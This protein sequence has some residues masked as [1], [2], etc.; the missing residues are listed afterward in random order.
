MAVVGRRFFY[1]ATEARHS[2]KSLLPTTATM[3]KV[4][5]GLLYLGD[6][7]MTIHG[8][9][10]ELNPN[11]WQATQF[12][13]YAKIRDFVFNMGLR[14]WQRQ[15]KQ[16]MKPSAW[17][18]RKQ[19]NGVKREYFPEVMEAPYA[20]IE[21]AFRD[22]GDAFKHFFRR[23]KN[24][25]K[26]GYPKPARYS[27]SFCV[28]NTRVEVNRVRI[29]R[30]IGWVRLK[31]RNYI[32][33]T[34]S[35]KRFGIY[36]TISHRAGRWFISVPAYTDNE[37]VESNGNVIGVDLGIH[38]LAVCSNGRVFE[39]PQPLRKAQCKLG[40][41]NKELARRKKGGQNWKKTKAKLQR[42]HYRVAN[43]RKHALHQVSSYLVKAVP[44]TIVLE[45]LN[46]K[47]MV[48]N[49]CLARAISD[50]G[51]GELR[52]QI[53]YKAGGAGIDVLV[54][55]RWMPSSK[56]CVRCGCIKKDL[57]LADRVFVCEHCGFEIDRDLNAAMNL[58]ALAE[59]LNGRGLPL[60]LG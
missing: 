9:K 55:D 53:E 6:G 11:N 28:K 27:N 40:Q 26:P 16:G 39:N 17:G 47:G 33:L 4:E 31:E 5:G 37:L 25:E 41:L 54:A 50:V 13:R 46:V 43:I 60:E 48:K 23:V 52:R 34:D 42:A 32:P 29:T 20:V 38:H 44:H 3:P 24:G 21:A 49:R 45:D 22:L 1:L 35:G 30:P 15:Y 59:P 36:A 56:T 7:L 57:T 19:F 58:A 18:L 10:T 2:S 8:Y 14:E 12:Q 51:F